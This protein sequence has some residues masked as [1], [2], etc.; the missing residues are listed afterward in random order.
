[1]IIRTMC[2]LPLH[3]KIQKTTELLFLITD[4]HIM[5]NFVEELDH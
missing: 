4:K 2:Q 3:G 1:M 5:Q